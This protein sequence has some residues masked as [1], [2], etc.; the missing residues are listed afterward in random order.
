MRGPSIDVTR[1][2]LCRTLTDNFPFV[3]NAAPPA[4]APAPPIDTTS[5]APSGPMHYYST[6]LPYGQPSAAPL[7]SE[8]SLPLPFAPPRQTA[9]P[10]PPSIAAQQHNLPSPSVHTPLSAS[11]AAPDYHSQSSYGAPPAY[12]SAQLPP[13]QPM[14]PQSMSPQTHQAPLSQYMPTP[15]E[16]PSLMSF[17]RVRSRLGS[18]G[19]T[20][21][22]ACRLTK[23]PLYCATICSRA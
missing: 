12:S 19:V 6:P 23:T 9:F 7:P 10:S 2:T 4:P 5:Y 3:L 1:L 17:Q 15:E 16:E 22:C 11:L 18:F 14:S 21:T 13:P 20:L 8:D